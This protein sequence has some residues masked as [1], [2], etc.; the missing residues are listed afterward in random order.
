MG[1]CVPRGVGRDCKG[2]ESHSG[3]L[4]TPVHYAD[5]WS[6]ELGWVVGWL[7]AF[8]SETTMAVVEDAALPGP[9][10][11]DTGNSR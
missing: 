1:R 7:T 5:R 4:R 11:F 2:S 10:Q 6:C 9:G 3:A 8:V